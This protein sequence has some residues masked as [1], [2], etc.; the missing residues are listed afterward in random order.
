MLQDATLYSLCIGIAGFGLGIDDADED[1]MD[2]YHSDATRADHNAR[3]A[4]DLDDQDNDVVMLGP[5]AVGANKVRRNGLPD[6]RQE[7]RTFKAP[8]QV[9]ASQENRTWNDGKPVIAG[10]VIDP[11]ATTQDKW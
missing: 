3:V 2:I 8:R 9:D 11:N 6:A 10:F 7:G 5:G 1:D 4:F